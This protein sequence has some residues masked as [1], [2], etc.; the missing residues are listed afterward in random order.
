MAKSVQLAV[1]SVPL[2]FRNEPSFSSR[3]NPRMTRRNCAA[4]RMLFYVSYYVLRILIVRYCMNSSREIKSAF[5]SLTAFMRA[6]AKYTHQP[7]NFVW[8]EY[9]SLRGE[10]VRLQSFPTHA[11][12]QKLIDPNYFDVK[13]QCRFSMQMQKNKITSLRLKMTS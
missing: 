13:F 5:L 2:H 9:L 1:Y 8:L 3:F 10:K 6:A 12:S 4:S 11:R 7:N